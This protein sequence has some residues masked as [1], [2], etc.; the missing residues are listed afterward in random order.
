[1]LSL[2]IFLPLVAAIVLAVTPQIG[3]TGARWLWLATATVEVVLVA[4][5]WARYTAPAAGRL[6]LDEKVK[7]IPGVRS[8]YHVGIKGSRYHW[9]R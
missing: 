8:S 6:A 9:S 3:D 2:V 1:M 5:V 7:W 4:I